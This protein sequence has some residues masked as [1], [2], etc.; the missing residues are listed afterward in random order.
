[1]LDGGGVERLVACGDFLALVF[2]RPR[3][4]AK[5]ERQK[6]AGDQ[7]QCSHPGRQRK[8]DRHVEHS[9]HNFAS[10][11]EGEIRGDAD[12]VDF[13]GQ[14]VSEIRS[15][16]AAYEQP[17]RIRNRTVE[18]TAQMMLDFL[19]NRI[20]PHVLH[21]S[22]HRSRANQHHEYAK[23]KNQR[24]AQSHRNEC[25]RN[26]RRVASRLAL[27]GE[28]EARHLQGRKQQREADPLAQRI[29]D[30]HDEHTDQMPA[31]NPHQHREIRRKRALHRRFCGTI[32]QRSLARQVA[33][34]D[35]VRNLRSPR[36]RRS[37]AMR[38]RR[39]AH[40]PVS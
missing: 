17:V 27:S 6:R 11:Y 19:L 2:D 32:G 8:R 15:A 10:E 40:Q 29:Q 37:R 30:R 4:A 21:L 34:I 13:R 14:R 33:R 20:S 16:T 7:H 35:R 12:S 38:E 9:D 25:I 22:Q 1:M 23:Q 26:D 3:A 39:N 36:C 24:R 5:S 31:R 18:A 28:I